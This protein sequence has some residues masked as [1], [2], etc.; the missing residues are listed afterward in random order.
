MWIIFHLHVLLLCEYVD[1]AAWHP[2]D[3]LQEHQN[4]AIKRVF[5][6]QDTDF[7]SS[8]LREV[9]GP[10]IAAFGYLREGLYRLFGLN[11]GQ[12]RKSK[13]D[14]AADINISL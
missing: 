10:N 1:N 2:H 12:S 9:V 5:P 6:D 8:F 11:H 13:T 3:L 7:D 4:F 14:T